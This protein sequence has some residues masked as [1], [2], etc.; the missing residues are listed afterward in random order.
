MTTEIA[1]DLPRVYVDHH[2]I[3]QVLCNLVTNAYQ[4]M[5]EGGD[6]TVSAQAEEEAVVLSVA[7]TGVGISEENMARLFEPL[8]TTKA[9]GLGLGLMVVKNLVEANEG[10]IEVV[11][12]MGK[13]STFT[14]RLPGKE[15][16]V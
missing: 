8:F 12:E 4:A 10:S 9:K 6:L 2:Q 13:G 14:V 7:D 16:G 5:P 11:S 1:P 15:T 3:R